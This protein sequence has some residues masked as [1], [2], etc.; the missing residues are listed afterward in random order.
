MRYIPPIDRQEIA[1]EIERD[2][3]DPRKIPTTETTKL[4]KWGASVEPDE[5]ITKSFIKKHI[6]KLLQINKYMSLA[7]YSKRDRYQKQIEHLR[8][9]KIP[10]FEDIG[11]PDD[12]EEVAI[13]SLRDANFTRGFEGFYTKEQNT[14]RQNVKQ[15]IQENKDA[16]SKLDFFKTKDEDKGHEVT[17]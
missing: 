16:K 9:M 6:R 14:L 5:I 11:L 2:G 8:G 17:W 10:M 7:N 1:E 13:D 3:F 15:N 12:A 4:L